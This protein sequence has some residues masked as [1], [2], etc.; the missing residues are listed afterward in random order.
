M[1]CAAIVAALLPT[2][3]TASAKKASFGVRTRVLSGWPRTPSAAQ[4]LEWLRDIEPRQ[5]GAFLRQL[6]T[7]EATHEDLGLSIADALLQ[8]S[9][10]RTFHEL[11]VHN[12]YY[13]PRIEMLRTLERRDRRQYGSACLPGAAWALI[14]PAGTPVPVAACE[15]PALH[16][17]LS[18]KTGSAGHAAAAFVPSPLDLELRNRG[19]AEGVVV[20]YGS[21]DFDSLPGIA[22]FLRVVDALDASS[23]WRVVFRHADGLPRPGGAGAD[24][25]T[26]YGFEL[27][28]KSSEY[29]THAEEKQEEGDAGPTEAA[30]DEGADSDLQQ[31]EEKELDVPVE[32]DGLLFHVLQQRYPNLRK[33]L[34]AF[35][36]QLEVERD[37]DQVLKAWEIKDIGLQATAKIK[38]SEAP[39]LAMMRLSQNFPAHVAGLS[40]TS[41]PQNLASSMSK[42]RQSLREHVEFFSINGRLVRPDRSDLSLFP[43]IKS[44]L[45]H[46]V[47]I[48][49]LVRMGLPETA[50]CELLKQSRGVT[51]PERLEWRSPELPP[52]SYIVTR[53]GKS[54][55][56][57]TTLQHLM[58]SYPGGLAPIRIPLFHVVFVF[59]PADASNLKT[60]VELLEQTPLPMSLHFVM[61]ENG[62]NA[63]RAEWDEEVL[64]RRP[65]WLGKGEGDDSQ[66]STR[67]RASHVIATAY[68]TLLQ[69]SRSKANA[70]L[71]ELRESMKGL[72]E[73]WPDTED[74]VKQLETIFRRHA[75]EDLLKELFPD[76]P[77]TD[78]LWLEM[79]RGVG[80]HS[81]HI[82]NGTKYVTGLGVP[83]PSMVINGKLLLKG[84][85]EDDTK[86]QTMGMEQQ[87][88]QRAV[89]TGQLRSASEIEDYIASKG[90]LSAYHPDITPE[91]ARRG[92]E[93]GMPGQT[94]QV[95]Y[96]QWPPASFLALPFLRSIEPHNLGD[97]PPEG[98]GSVAQQSTSRIGLFHVTV[99]RE[100]SHS[101][102]LSSFA[103]H[104][105][106]P[107]RAVLMSNK[108]LKVPPLSSYWSVIVDV[109]GANASG[110]GSTAMAE[111]RACVRGTLALEAQPSEDDDGT[112]A[113]NRRKLQMLKFLGLALPAAVAESAREGSAASTPA[114]I[115]EL[116][117][118][119][120]HKK[121][122][123]EYHA[124]AKALISAAQWPNDAA[125]EA[126]LIAAATSGK[127]DDSGEALWVCNGRRIALK[128]SGQPV[129]ARHVQALELMEAQY[130]VGEVDQDD[131]LEQQQS[132]KSKE[133]SSV[134][135]LNEW[136]VGADELPVLVGQAHGLI[137]AI[138]SEALLGR[139]KDKGPNHLEIFERTPAPF[140][141]MLPRARPEAAS[142]ITVFGIL[143]PLSTTAQSASAVLALFGMAFNA[144]VYLVLN[145][146]SRHSEY[147]LKRYYREVI[148]WP[149]HL[150]DGRAVADLNNGEG[151]VG[152]GLGEFAGLVTKHTLTAAVHQLPTWLVTAFE[153]EHDMD[154]LRQVDLGDERWCESTYILRQLYVEGQAFVLGEDGW[155]IA[156][157]KGLQIDVFGQGGEEALDDTIVMGNL[158]YFQVHGNPGL[159]QPKLKPGLSNDTF[160]A[161]NIQDVEVSSYITPPYQLRVRLRPGRQLDDLFEQ[162]KGGSAPG[163]RGH[164][165]NALSRLFGS[166]AFVWG[167][168]QE[169]EEESEPAALPESTGDKA[170]DPGS[171]TIH[172]FSVASGH[173]YEK[174]LGIM[175]LSVRNQTKNPLHFWFI[176]NF[177]SP[178]FKQFIPQMARR[179]SFGYAFITYKW[180]SWLNPQTEKQRLIWAYKVLFLD[181]L[182]PLDVPKVL[183]IDADQVVRA[184]VL[185]LWNMDLQ[186]KVYGFVPMGDTNPDTEGF[187]FWKQGYWKNH[188]GD[189][190]YHI[191][192][193]YVV[194]LVEFRRTSIG[195]QLR[196]LYNQLSR[197]A[198]SLSNLEQDLINFAQHQIPI[199]SLPAEWLWCETWCSQETKPKAKTI[200]LCQNP[201]TKEPKIVMAKR[202]ISEWQTYH[203]EVQR[204]QDGL[205]AAATPKGMSGQGSNT[206]YSVGKAEL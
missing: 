119:G 176:D 3:L 90:L 92:G 141:L 199:F 80:V 115:R 102:L 104:L 135:T 107:A 136:L 158:G 109:A 122:D 32:M 61:H 105:I 147:P 52:P 67:V 202:I 76:Q 36:E 174:L 180:P 70:F 75:S 79:V 191:S 29:K 17:E 198:N 110:A 13:S 11:L 129:S 15:V 196:G 10:V 111:L 99:L 194:D 148:R 57:G 87:T 185:E 183:F 195:D 190:P 91:A 126:A 164:M 23:N 78:A 153:A 178:K 101:Y 197:D 69:K 51:S 39:L 184:D 25:L 139:D 22:P 95:I 85:Y 120:V 106:A 42:L 41:V 58:Y 9:S 55:R 160:E 18:K 151:E 60:A 131:D 130:D 26:G 64:G 200:D 49:R 72:G 103:S 50:A 150:P 5:A 168:A 157:A 27:A 163:R 114:R 189:M 118:L 53:D 152:S 125:D 155:P 83:V 94:T 68:G 205:V 12:F 124:Q 188:L 73:R 138:R 167:G 162:G 38:A 149:V 93:E 108:Q 145:P 21:V 140:K 97:S 146:I 123:P 143:D 98:E 30:G 96:V 82:I 66:G 89:Y 8:S 77:S 45:P 113:L 117:E 40:R 47:G 31:T 37:T 88:F 65:E 187:R 116:C 165:D 20:L 203:D 142:P 33:R 2:V 132:G 154:N 112:D 192:A 100:L 173:L 35:K 4:S 204:F 156:S 177:L 172:I 7:G 1:L 54:K 19:S 201:L 170:S 46:F 59:D 44:L 71:K 166:L 181:V 63:A 169:Q 193:L 62:A 128:D 121:I 74:G 133:T 24:L 134:K 127:N 171:A 16:V 182:F 159:Y 179:Y 48:E 175:I 81:G 144:E 56:W 137:A 206:T 28:I 14:W 34:R 43:M 86:F 84:A 186:G 6:A 161:A